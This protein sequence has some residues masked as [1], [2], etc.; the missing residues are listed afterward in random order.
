[1][2]KLFLISY[3]FACL[4]LISSVPLVKAN[5]LDNGLTLSFF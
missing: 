5:T 3:L 1:M 2:T 4:T